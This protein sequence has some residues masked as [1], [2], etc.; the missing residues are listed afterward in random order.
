MK[1][2]FLIFGVVIFSLC[3]TGPQLEEANAAAAMSGTSSITVRNHSFIPG[4][5]T[6]LTSGDIKSGDDSTN[7]PP[8]QFQISNS[9]SGDSGDMSVSGDVNLQSGTIMVNGSF[10]FQDDPQCFPELVSGGIT[11]RLSDSLHFQSSDPLVQVPLTFSLTGNE[12]R[13]GGSPSVG[14]PLFN[15]SHLLRIGDSLTL[16]VGNNAAI[17]AVCNLVFTRSDNQ[18]QGSPNSGTS[19]GTLSISLGALPSGVTCTS[20]SGVFP[21]CDGQNPEPEVD[22]ALSNPVITQATLLK[23]PFNEGKYLTTTQQ[24]ILNRRAAVLVDVDLL[25]GETSDTVIV[26]GQYGDQLLDPVP[27]TFKEGATKGQAEVF[28]TPTQTGSLTQLTLKVDPDDAIPETDENNNDLSV[29]EYNVVETKIF[30]VPSFLIDH[31]G[32]KTDN[33]PCLQAAQEFSSFIDKSNQFLWDIFPLPNLN[34]PLQKIGELITGGGVLT[35]LNPPSPC[36]KVDISLGIYTDFW[37]LDRRRIHFGGKRGLGIVPENYFSFHKLKDDVFGLRLPINVKSVMSRTGTAGTSTKPPAPEQQRTAIPAHELLHTFGFDEGYTGCG[38]PSGTEIVGFKVRDGIPKEQR[39]VENAYD[40]MDVAETSSQEPWINSIHWDGLAVSL[41]KGGQ[42]PALLSLGAILEKDGTVN[43][44]PWRTL[45]GVPDFVQAGD[46][47]VL[48]VDR[49]GQT[50]LNVPFEPGFSMTL[51][52]LGTVETD[53]ALLAFALP[54][55][56]ESALVKIIGANGEEFLSVD[57]VQKILRDSIDLNSDQA[58]PDQCFIGN[59]ES[60]PS[61]P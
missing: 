34:L 15:S 2:K 60:D 18:P 56:A 14:C 54:Y 11:M 22:L 7:T 3:G 53:I 9:N 30:N 40:L 51:D 41:Q 58:I 37:K 39:L 32:C 45:N 35:V 29:T 50:I 8:F 10:N 1:R 48:F 61:H 38:D 12:I 17:S 47:S 25:S 55:P 13:T 20:D 46:Y 28:F 33:A 4:T 24:L 57:P 21:G 44:L 42:D 59:S 26:G 19:T 31:P 27:A 52:P 49:K 6:C 36:G 43:L 5:T 16:M 23:D